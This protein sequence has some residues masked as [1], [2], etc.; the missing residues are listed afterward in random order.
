[1]PSSSIPHLIGVFILFLTVFLCQNQFY[2]FFLQQPGQVEIRLSNYRRVYWYIELQSVIYLLFT[3]SFIFL[4]QFFLHFIFGLLGL[5]GM[6]NYKDI[7]LLVLRATSYLGVLQQYQ[8]LLGLKFGT[9]AAIRG[10]LIF[11]IITTITTV[12]F[13]PLTIAPVEIQEPYYHFI[14]VSFIW[15]VM[16]LFNYVHYQNTGGYQNEN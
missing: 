4:V 11:F 12:W 1:M 5:K 7:I 14:G 2:N 15:I 9:D 3:V 8:L 6:G 13:S 10:M 16:T